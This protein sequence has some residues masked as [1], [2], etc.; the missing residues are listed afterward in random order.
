RRR[1]AA[2]AHRSRRPGGAGGRRLARRLLRRAGTL[3]EPEL[4]QASP[5]RPERRPLIRR[6]FTGGFSAGCAQAV[7][8]G[9]AGGRAGCGLAPRFV[10]GP[11]CHLALAGAATRR[12]ARRGPPVAAT[13][14]VSI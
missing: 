14:L 10:G 1:P 5:G 13:A 12:H 8:A 3:L 2:L 9:A 4:A 7:A 11:G 6:D